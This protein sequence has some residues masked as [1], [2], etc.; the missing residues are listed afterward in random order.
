MSGVNLVFYQATELIM[1]VI[2]I[3]VILKGAVKE[4][5]KGV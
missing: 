1:V 2:L 4:K 3:S 5:W